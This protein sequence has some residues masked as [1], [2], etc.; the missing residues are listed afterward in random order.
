MGLFRNKSEAYANAERA[1]HVVAGGSPHAAIGF[2]G[3]PQS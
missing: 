2:V 1:A 3:R